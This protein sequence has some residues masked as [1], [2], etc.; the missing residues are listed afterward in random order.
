MRSSFFKQ[1]DVTLALPTDE[2]M[3]TSADLLINVTFICNVCLFLSLFDFT[4]I[5]SVTMFIDLVM[6]FRRYHFDIT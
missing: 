5:A 4:C 3:E 1:R 6:K 2:E